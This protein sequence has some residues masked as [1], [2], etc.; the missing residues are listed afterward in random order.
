MPG[1]DSRDRAARGRAIAANI[2]IGDRHVLDEQMPA[3]DGRHGIELLGEGH[4]LRYPQV[5]HDRE[6]QHE[7]EAARGAGE[8]RFLFAV[9]RAER[10]VGRP[11]FPTSGRI[12]RL[13][14]RERR[15]IAATERSS[16]SSATTSPCCAAISL[17]SPVLAPMSRV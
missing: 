11:K 5:M 12:G 7:V 10:G 6:H 15:Q 13:P 3:R 16:M 1:A 14:S 8:Q 2:A 4:A 9:A 17:Y